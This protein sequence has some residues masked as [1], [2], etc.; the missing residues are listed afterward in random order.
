VLVTTGYG[1]E[2]YEKQRRDWPRQPDYVAGNL[3]DAVKWILGIDGV[4]R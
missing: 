2:E 4:K 3:L 1:R